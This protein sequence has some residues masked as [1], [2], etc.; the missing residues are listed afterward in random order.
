VVLNGWLLFWFSHLRF[1]SPMKLKS[2]ILA[3]LVAGTAFAAEPAPFQLKGV[4]N[5]GREKLFGLSTLAG[6]NSA[7]VPLGKGF[8]G[9]TLKSYDDAKSILVFEHEGKTF[10][11]ALATAKIATADAVKGTPA[12]IAD[13]A[14]VIDRMH[15]EEMMGKV[16][17]QQKKTMSGG[18]AQQMVKQMGSKVDPKDFADFQGKV[19]DVMQEA[20]N[21]P[22]LKK[23]ITGIYAETFTKEELTA[24]SDFY[25]TPAGQALNDKQPDVQQKLQAI[26]MPRI[27][28]AMPKVQQLGM[29]FGKEQQA[30]AEAAAAAAQPAQPAPAP[31]TK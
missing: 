10:E 16:M 13:A 18:M 27:M 20:M 28:S 31:A 1:L 29:E 24:M 23:D 4:L 26:M 7:W 19:M 5:T 25:A 22:Q 9:Y 17:D 21:L 3:F 8:Q 6:D 12:T 2:L 11:L 30:K 15:F 14:A